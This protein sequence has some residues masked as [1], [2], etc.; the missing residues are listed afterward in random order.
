M[1]RTLESSSYE[2]E[3]IQ[4]SPTDE[5]L[6]AAC[7][8]GIARVWNPAAHNRTVI[9]LNHG[10]GVCCAVFSPGR[11]WIVTG[12]DDGQ[13]KVWQMG[14]GEL[15]SD[16][17]SA[18]GEPV[19]DIKFSAD[20]SLMGI[21]AARGT[22]AKDR[23]RRRV[24]IAE[25]DTFEVKAETTDIS[26]GDSFA[27]DVAQESVVVASQ[28]GKLIR[29][30]CDDGK[31][32]SMLATANAAYGQISRLPGAELLVVTDLEGETLFLDEEL[33]V[34]RKLATHNKS[35]GVID[36]S[37]DGQFILVGSGDG[38][39][40]LISAAGALQQDTVW[41]DGPVRS[42]AFTNDSKAVVMACSDG[43]VRRWD[44]GKSTEV[45]CGDDRGRA[46][47]GL[48]VDSATGHVAAC[49]MMW[50][51]RI[52][53]PA[54]MTVVS[55]TTLPFGGY[56][57]VAWSTDGKYV[58]VGSRSGEVLTYESADL[59]KTVSVFS[60]PEGIVNAIGFIDSHV[61]ATAWDNHQLSLIDVATGRVV[62]EL[63][64]LES[65]PL[66]LAC[67]QKNGLIV[68]GTQAGALHFYSL[69]D[70]TERTTVRAHAGLVSAI[71]IFPN[72]RQLVSG[73]LDGVLSIW[74]VASGELVGQ[75]P[76]HGRHRTFAVAVSPDGN[77]IA[78]SGLEGDVR[79]WRSSVSNR[80]A[81]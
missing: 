8:D 28:N 4:Y 77:T 42:V 44:S 13:V 79:L 25:T 20:G 71:A 70:Q 57:A 9:E 67:D 40:R 1:A 5:R 53:D 35:F 39:A 76:G 49:G 55:K 19:Y 2:Y 38:S 29:Y 51:L 81:P 30:R 80:S 26:F 33:R 65:A 3:S 12:S 72:G 61:V 32:T 36:V 10:P 11:N 31:P 24:R 69:T 17:L 34:V 41:L 6:L 62:S 63:A 37:L 74:D 47:R 15:V 68:V 75:L 73:G 45:I 78:S 16:E 66:S 22:S 48:A 58:S 52:A 21:L 46:V 50:E 27:F 23:P 56:S 43:A 7:S 64:T 60:Q 59:S 54:R 18:A 14:T